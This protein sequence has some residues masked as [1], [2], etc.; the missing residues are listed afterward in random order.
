MKPASFSSELTVSAIGE[1]VILKSPNEPAGYKVVDHYS[2]VGQHVPS[3]AIMLTQYDCTLAELLGHYYADRLS[4]VISRASDM[5]KPFL[6]SYSVISAYVCVR[7]GSI[8]EI[9]TPSPEYD[10]DPLRVFVE[11]TP[12]RYQTPQINVCLDW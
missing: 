8:W 12:L 9:K 6:P 5:E 4:H 2:L 3:D 10:G 7:N 1:L 11:Q